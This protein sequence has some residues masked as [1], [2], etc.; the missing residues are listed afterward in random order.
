MTIRKMAFGFLAVTFLA[1][2][3]EEPAPEIPPAPAP[4]TDAPEEVPDLIIPEN[5]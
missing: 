1:A 5:E 4:T 3:G 2:C